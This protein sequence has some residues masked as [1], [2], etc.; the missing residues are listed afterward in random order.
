MVTEFVSKSSSCSA[1]LQSQS[2]LV[3]SGYAIIGNPILGKPLTLIAAKTANTVNVAANAILNAAIAIWAIPHN[4]KRI[5][6][7]K[8]PAFITTPSPTLRIPAAAFMAA[9][10]VCIASKPETTASYVK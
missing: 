8:N 3:Q 9:I 7:P 2:Q 5:V 4:N 1:F 6:S 10:P